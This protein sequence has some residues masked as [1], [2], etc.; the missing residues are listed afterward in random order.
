MHLLMKYLTENEYEGTVR[1]NN[2]DIRTIDSDSVYQKIGYIQRN[3]FL[4]DGSVK[5]NIVLYRENISNGELSQVCQD[6]KLNSEL[7]QKEIGTSDSG[8]VSFGEKQRIDIA[9]FMVHNYDVLVFDEPTSNLDAETANEIFNM[10]FSIQDKIVIVIT[11][12][13][14]KEV[15]GRFDAVLQ[16]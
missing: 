12:D 14:S 5:D 8:E 11:H 3:E 1:I 10:I 6:L 16:L 7:V 4:I 15:L 13:R 2:Q 9:R